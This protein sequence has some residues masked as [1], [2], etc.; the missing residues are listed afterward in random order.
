MSSLKVSLASS[1]KKTQDYLDIYFGNQL[2]KSLI[3]GLP[4]E[5]LLRNASTLIK[6]KVIEFI[7]TKLGSYNYLDV[8]GI[9]PF[10]QAL[11]KNQIANIQAKTLGFKGNIFLIFKV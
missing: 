8:K 7:K 11:G 5:F 6:P 2:D 1:N 4:D 10:N 9:I 3:S